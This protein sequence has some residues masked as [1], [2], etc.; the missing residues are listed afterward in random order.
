MIEDA[1]A[2]GMDYAG[3][4]DAAKTGKARYSLTTFSD[5]LTIS[6]LG[7]ITYA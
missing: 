3:I 7:G 2:A 6:N 5:I 4:G 1:S